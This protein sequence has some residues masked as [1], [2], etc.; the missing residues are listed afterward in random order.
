[1]NTN[2]TKTTVAPPDVT[3]TL[4]YDDAT[5]ATTYLTG[6]LGF[7]EGVVNRDADGRVSHAELRWGNGMVMVGERRQGHGEA[8]PF[9]FGPQCIYLLTDEPDRLH[10]RLVDAGADVVM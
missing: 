10:D 1:M 7:T 4:T 9:E 3:P 5:A 2:H 8:S 6:T